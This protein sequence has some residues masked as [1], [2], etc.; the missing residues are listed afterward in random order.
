MIPEVA[1]AL[2]EERLARLRLF[3]AVMCGLNMTLILGLRTR[4]ES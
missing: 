3:E 1:F 4:M 2:D